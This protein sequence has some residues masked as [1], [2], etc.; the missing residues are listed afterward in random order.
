[1]YEYQLENPSIDMIIDY[2]HDLLADE[3]LVVYDFGKNGD[4]VLH[5]YKDEYYNPE[6]DEEYSDIVTIVTMQNGE[7]VDDTED[8]YVTD[9]SLYREL[10]RIQNY[11]DFGTL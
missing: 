5:I 1:M 4:L 9:G 6:V 2:C 8:T 10:E 3:K 11:E 7:T